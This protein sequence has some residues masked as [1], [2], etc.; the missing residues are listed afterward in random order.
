VAMTMRS[1]DVVRRVAVLAYHSSPLEEPGAGDAG[2]MGVYVRE[3]AAAHAA[4]G[5][6]T[7]IFTRAT[8]P[9]GGTVPWSPHVRVVPVAAGPRERLPKE[10]APRYIE[11]FTSNLKAFAVTQR[12]TYDVVHSHY[13]QSG[14]AG[15]PLRN[16]WSVPLVHSQHT[17]GLV[18]NRYLPPGEPPEPEARIRGEQRVIAEADVLIASTDD[19]WQQLSCLYGAVHDRLETVHPGVDH[20]MFRPGDARRARTQLRLAPEEP[21]LLCVG[22]IQPLKGLEVALEATRDLIRLIG[23]DVT[24]VVAGGPS[25]PSGERYLERLRKLAMDLGLET[26]VRFVG[27][28]PRAQLPDFYRAADALL[29]CSRTES[30]GL[31]ALEAQAC[32]VPVVGTPVGGLTGVVRDGLS[33]WI[34]RDSRP[35]AFASTLADLLAD[36]TRRRSFSEAA[37]VA[38]RGFPWERTAEQ[39][40]ELYDCLVHAPAPEVCTC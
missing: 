26:R 3:V 25:G 5:V 8:A 4:R 35:A 7:D 36:E 17:L 27:P 18:K 10:V 13:W 1:R 12:I 30:F 33:G 39:L 38:A 9:L 40:L 21:V 24:L 22:R 16:A 15:L 29:V 11:E 28:R 23:R 37:V 14:L 19:E 20:S 34:V 31:T 32:G 6:H 2:G